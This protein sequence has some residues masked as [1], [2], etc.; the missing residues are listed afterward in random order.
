[1]FELHEFRSPL[2]GSTGTIA[3][4]RQALLLSIALQNGRFDCGGSNAIIP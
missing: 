1:M 2:D 3:F 4:A